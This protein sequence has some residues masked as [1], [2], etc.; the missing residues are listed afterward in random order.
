MTRGNAIEAVA[1]QITS[2]T[3]RR[4]WPADSTAATAS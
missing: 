2:P 3:S 4:F 1:S